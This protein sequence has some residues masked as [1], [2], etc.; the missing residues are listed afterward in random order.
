LTSAR[1]EMDFAVLSMAIGWSFVTTGG[2]PA[3][4]D[5]RGNTSKMTIIY[6]N[7]FIMVLL[8]N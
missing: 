8:K 3:K 2:V 4:A 7:F 1:K 6:N 5:W